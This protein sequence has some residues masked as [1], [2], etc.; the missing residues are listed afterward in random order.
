MVNHQSGVF[1]VRQCSKEGDVEY[2]KANLLVVLDL[3]P[4]V[5]GKPN[6]TVTAG[7]PPIVSDC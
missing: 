6:A 7:H 3:V 1:N 4:D 5:P 2:E